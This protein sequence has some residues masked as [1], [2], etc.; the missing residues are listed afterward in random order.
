M[1]VTLRRFQATLN[2]RLHLRPTLALAIK[3]G[4]PHPLKGRMLAHL[5][6]LLEIALSRGIVF[7][8]FG[9][10]SSQLISTRRVNLIQTQGNFFGFISAAAH[11]SRRVVIKLP[12]I[13]KCI[14]IARI[15]A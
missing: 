3:A 6:R 5:N 12:Q 7:E 9:N 2:G 10:S 1:P 4:K 13:G 15:R 14:R 8:L 11:N